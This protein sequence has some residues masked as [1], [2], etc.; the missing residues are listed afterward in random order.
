MSCPIEIERRVLYAVENAATASLTEEGRRENYL[1]GQRNMRVF[2]HYK[3]T[4]LHLDGAD[5]IHFVCILFLFKPF[6]LPHPPT[7]LITL[8]FIKHH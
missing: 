1:F 2:F 3:C 8:S 5:Y 4:N 7:Y 6:S